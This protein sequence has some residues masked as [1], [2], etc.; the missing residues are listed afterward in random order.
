MKFVMS[1]VMTILLFYKGKSFLMSDQFK[2]LLKKTNSKNWV[3]CFEKDMRNK[4]TNGS[5]RKT[6][7]SSHMK[8]KNVTKKR[9]K[10]L[11]VNN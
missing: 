5:G 2:G 3:F 6:L 10:F 1:F 7:S 9:S 11:N 4:A 8:T